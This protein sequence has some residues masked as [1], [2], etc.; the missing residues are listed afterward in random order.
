MSCRDCGI[1]G[2][3]AEECQNPKKSL[4]EARERSKQND[5]AVY[6]TSKLK[7]G[8]SAPSKRFIWN[9]DEDFWA[10]G[11]EEVRELRR[12]RQNAHEQGGEL[13]DTR[14]KELQAAVKKAST[15]HFGNRP[16][17]VDE[18]SFSPIYYDGAD[19]I[20][21]TPR[22][23]KRFALA[24]QPRTSRRSIADAIAPSPIRKGAQANLWKQLQRSNLSASDR[25]ILQDAYYHKLEQDLDEDQ[26][27][28]RRKIDEPCKLYPKE[29]IN[30]A[31]LQ[32]ER[33]ILEQALS[34]QVLEPIKWKIRLGWQFYRDPATMWAV[35]E[36]Q[37]P[38]CS[39]PSCQSKGAILD[40]HMNMIELGSDIMSLKDWQNWG[41]F[42]VFSC[43]CSKPTEHY[44][45][46]GYHWE[47]ARQTD[48]E[49]AEKRARIQK[50]V[51]KAMSQE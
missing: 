1:K 30:T 14:E 28:Y 12:E 17:V 38:V 4:R 33:W 13:G 27:K 49:E 37:V 50:A 8:A 5:D 51:V 24:G 34:N 25:R 42:V 40:Q 19:V 32:Q 7:E 10:P 36:K 11:F 20:M 43:S 16:P 23:P 48:I 31:I 22:T 41:L 29:W 21:R 9:V 6:I 35:H 44:G 46:H 47:M 15:L 26:R 18:A 45:G 2:H 39:N 3:T